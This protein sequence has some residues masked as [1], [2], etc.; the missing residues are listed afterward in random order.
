[1]TNS[2]EPSFICPVSHPNCD[3]INEIDRLRQELAEVSELVHTDTLTG[4]NNYRF[5]I[6]ALEQELERTR[7]TGYATGFIMV[8]LDHF[9]RI[10]DEY[11]HDS[12]NLALQHA[13]RLL[14]ASVR[15][16]DLPCRYGGEEFAVILPSSTLESSIQVAERIRHSLETNPLD[17]PDIQLT[18]TASLGVSLYAPTSYG[19]AQSLIK[20]ADKYLYEAKE[21]GRNQVSHEPLKT[22]V[23]SV[24]DEEKDALFDIFSDFK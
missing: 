7:R 10:N 17:L 13:A 8:D 12:G 15:K 5:L 4:L 11:G 19:D 6:P 24:S 21:N 22:E 14:R 16:I 2:I 9:K 3:A 1:M 18:I 23:A 20:T